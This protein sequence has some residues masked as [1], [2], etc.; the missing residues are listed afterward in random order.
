MQLFRT[1]QDPGR[2]FLPGTIHQIHNP[3]WCIRKHI[4][5]N[6]KKNKSELQYYNSEYAFKRH[7]RLI[8]IH[9]KLI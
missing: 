4:A 5:T 1:L 9:I 8:L 3:E 7:E 6:S 2:D